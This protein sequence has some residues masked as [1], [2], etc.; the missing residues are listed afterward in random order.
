MADWRLKGA[1][2]EYYGFCRLVASR[3]A[4]GL[5]TTVKC[6][7]IASDTQVHKVCAHHWWTPGLV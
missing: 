5:F 6:P 4:W 7:R 3:R 1:A 2:C